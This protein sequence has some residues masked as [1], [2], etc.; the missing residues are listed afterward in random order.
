MAVPQFF[1]RKLPV[2][3]VLPAP[4]T[5]GLG[6]GVRTAKSSRSAAMPRWLTIG[7]CLM[8][9]N[10]SALTRFLPNHFVFSMPRPLALFDVDDFLTRHGPLGLVRESSHIAN[11]RVK[12]TLAV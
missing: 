3:T 6:Q 11:K 2:E 12:A 10:G 9:A 1:R 8:P 5:D 4:T 7:H